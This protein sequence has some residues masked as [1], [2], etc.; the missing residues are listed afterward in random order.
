MSGYGQFVAS[1]YSLGLTALFAKK[2]INFH[3]LKRE[4]DFNVR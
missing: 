3:I 1:I 2:K 4:I